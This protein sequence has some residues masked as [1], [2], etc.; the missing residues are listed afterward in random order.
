[1]NIT[2]GST[3]QKERAPFAKAFDQAK[4]AHDK[5][6][7]AAQKAME[8][9]K[10][11]HTAKVAASQKD[12]EGK[13]ADAQQIVAKSG[14]ELRQAKGTLDQFDTAAMGA[15]NSL[16]NGASTNAKI[17]ATTA[18]PSKRRSTK[19]PGKRALEGR[20]EVKEGKRPPIAA[21]IRLILGTKT[22]S[23]PEIQAELERLNWMPVSNNPRTYISYALS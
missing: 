10:E 8:Q 14:E 19:N 21:A 23:T 22:M 12:Y 3:L 18:A 4:A 16:R 20:Q 2:I 7:S 11:A 17:P 13:V 9:A 5:K 6:V 1:M 15:L